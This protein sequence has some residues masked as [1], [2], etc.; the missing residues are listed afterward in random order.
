VYT[1]LTLSW[2]Y[3][4]PSGMV[5]VSPNLPFNP[6]VQLALILVLIYDTTTRSWS[7]LSQPPSPVGGTGASLP[8]LSDQ[9]VSNLCNVGSSLVVALSRDQTGVATD[10]PQN[11]SVAGCEIQLLSADS[12]TTVQG[13]FLW[14]FGVLLA[15]D[16]GAHNLAPWLPLAPQAEIAAVGG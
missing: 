16:K 2:R 5:A 11:Q 4:S 12:A 3:T 6:S 13:T 10:M 1:G 15:V 7:V 8:T 9:L 14:R